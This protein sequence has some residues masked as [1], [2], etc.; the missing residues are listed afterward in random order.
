M[1]R[2]VPCIAFLVPCMVFSSLAF[3]QTATPLE[4]GF[5]ITT[6]RLSATVLDG[7]IVSLKDLKSG[8]VHADT[9][10]ADLSMPRGLGSMIGNQAAMQS[11]HSPWGNQQMK[12]DVP[13]GTAFPTMHFP[14]PQGKFVATAIKGGMRGVWT[15][16]TNG[17]GQFPQES[18]R[19]PNL[20]PPKPAFP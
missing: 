10:V 13:P 15:G 5:T 3:A 1:Q 17:K 2:K 6:P 9:A 11:L 12:Q 18:L 14:S 19:C 16:L 7:A 8:E 4:R 20:N